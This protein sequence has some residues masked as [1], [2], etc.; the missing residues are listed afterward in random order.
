MVH[1]GRQLWPR[2]CRQPPPSGHELCGCV[3]CEE[4]TYEDHILKYDEYEDPEQGQLH[5]EEVYIE[6]DDD[7]DK[8]IGIY[9]ESD[10]DEK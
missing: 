6:R 7:L 4:K 9:M 8:H 10:D 5:L 2:S 3:G 1:I